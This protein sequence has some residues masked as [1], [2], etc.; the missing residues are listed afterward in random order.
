MEIEA[1]MILFSSVMWGCLAVSIIIVSTKMEEED[2]ALIK[3]AKDDQV[4]DIPCCGAHAFGFHPRTRGQRLALLSSLANH[5]TAPSQLW[6]HTILFA[7]AWDHPLPPQST[8]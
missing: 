7:F 2:V 6:L 8:K 4:H 1:F 5:W 3:A